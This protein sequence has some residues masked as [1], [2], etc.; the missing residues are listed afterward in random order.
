LNTLV[1]FERAEPRSSGQFS[2]RANSG[3]FET[4]AAGGFATIMG[5]GFAAFQ[6]VV[7]HHNMQPVAQLSA[8]TR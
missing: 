3:G 7:L 5:G 2:A 6:V 4:I 8:I 1:N